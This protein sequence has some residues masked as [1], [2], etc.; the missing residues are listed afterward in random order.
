MDSARIASSMK[1]TR[2]TK[3]WI[4]ILAAGLVSG[5][6]GVAEYGWNIGD[7]IGFAFWI[8]LAICVAII[9]RRDNKTSTQL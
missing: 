1:F 7:T 6:L 3:A 2:A 9:V 4:L 5:L 8:A